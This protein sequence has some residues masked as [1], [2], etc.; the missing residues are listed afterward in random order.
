MNSMSRTPGD[1]SSAGFD[2]VVADRAI[3]ALLGLA[4]GDAGK[5]QLLGQIHEPQPGVWERYPLA[6]EIRE[7]A[8]GSFRRKKPPEIQGSGYVVKSLEAALWAFH[9]TDDFRSGA[10]AAVNLGDDADTTGAIYGQIAGM[11]WG[12]AGLPK[13][14]LRPTCV[15]LAEQAE[16]NRQPACGASGLGGGIRNEHY[17]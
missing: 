16:L 5:Q 10:L 8:E 6:P 4:L 11:Y 14:W 7:I 3:G 13:D 1:D 12:L 9:H 15:I 17:R 2:P